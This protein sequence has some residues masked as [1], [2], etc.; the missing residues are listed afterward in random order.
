MNKKQTVE[1]KR[2]KWRK[3]AHAGV[4]V[5]AI[6]RGLS[7]VLAVLLV[8]GFLAAASASDGENLGAQFAGLLGG[9]FLLLILNAGARALQLLAILV[10]LSLDAANSSKSRGAT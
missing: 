5:A 10:H 1:G 3:A 6:F 4:D 9:L 2:V 8:V 7:V